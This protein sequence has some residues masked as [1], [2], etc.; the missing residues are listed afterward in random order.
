MVRLLDRT[1]KPEL[2]S[3]QPLLPETTSC[4][5]TSSC[6]RIGKVEDSV[7]A[8]S[9]ISWRWVWT[10]TIH[11]ICLTPIMRRWGWLLHHQV[12]WNLPRLY[13]SI[14]VL[15]KSI[16]PQ[17]KLH[18]GTQLNL[19]QATGLGCLLSAPVEDEAGL[20]HHSYWR[21]DFSSPWLPSY[22]CGCWSPPIWVVDLC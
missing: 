15:A 19:I 8:K 3:S 4:M 5:I 1:R 10:L 20:Y 6:C 13:P 9:I 22:Y 2:Y 18:K 11:L 16:I 12:S 14:A 21:L 17:V 7:L